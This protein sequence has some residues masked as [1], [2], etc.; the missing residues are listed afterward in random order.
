MKKQEVELT[1]EQL[2]AEVWSMPMVELAK[3]YGISDVGLSKVCKRN[4]IPKPPVGYWAK[5]AHGKK[6]KKPALPKMEDAKPVRFQLSIA[7]NIEIEDPELAAETERLLAFEALAENRIVVAKRLGNLHPFTEAIQAGRK[8]EKARISFLLKVSDPMTSRALRVA[9]ALIR[10]L[11]A[12]G[13]LEN[14]I[15]GRHTDLGIREIYDSVLKESTKQRMKETGA[16]KAGPWGDYDHIPTGRLR[17][18]IDPKCYYFREGFRHNWA[19]GKTRRIE[20]FSNDVICALIEKAAVKK[21][22]KS[23]GSA[24]SRNVSN[25]KSWR[26]KKPSGSEE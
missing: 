12:R 15:F 4:K 26:A 19:D 9:D 24:K 2:Y 22:M 18:Q 14:G 25:G 13:F 21:M 6:V 7:K 10:A 23:D 20:D 1:R 11:D 5:V 17:L 16:T 3:K 8:W